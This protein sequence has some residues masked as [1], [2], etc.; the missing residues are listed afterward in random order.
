MEIIQFIIKQNGHFPNS[1]LPL[2]LYKNVL[3]LPDGKSEEIITGIFT[4]NNWSNIWT[5]GI[6]PYHH[7]HSNT[8]EVLGIISGECVVLL[9]GEKGIQCTLTKGDVIIIPAGVAHKSVSASDDFKCAGAYPD[10]KE[11][12]I[13][14]GSNGEQQAAE[15]SIQRVPL[16]DSDPVYGKQGPLFEYWKKAAPAPKRTGTGTK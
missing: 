11:Y 7:Y 10:G 9:G 13:K 16:P 6:Y 4:D 12:D 1:A 14:Y 15:E 8:H 2:L 3:K 5:N